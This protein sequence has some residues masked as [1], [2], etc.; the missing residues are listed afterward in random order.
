MK[1]D[2]NEKIS[3][4]EIWK[5]MY[6]VMLLTLAQKA[7]S[8]FEGIL[9][10]INNSRELTVTSVCGPYISIIT[11]V[12][13]GLGIAVQV[14]TARINGKQDWK[15]AGRAILG[16]I[17][18]MVLAC[19]I[20]ISC[21]SAIL[22]YP[23]FEAAPELRQ[24]GYLYM[25]PYLLG[26]P[27]ILLYHIII[28]EL[29]GF[30][31]TRTGMW[32]TFLSVPIQLGLCWLFYNYIGFT[33]MGYSMLISRISG[34]IY[35]LRKSNN[36][37]R[38]LWKEEKTQLP[39]GFFTEFISLALPI[40]LSK[41]ISPSANAVMNSLLLTMGT[42]IVAVSGLGNRLSVFFYL[43]ATAVGVAAV[44]LVPGIQNKTE[45]NNICRRLC[46]WSV[47]PTFVLVLAAYIFRVPI[48]NLLSADMAV[49]SVG[50]EYWKICLVAYPLISIEMTMTSLLQA[51]GYGMPTLVITTVRIWGVQLPLT[52]LAKHLGFHA[53]GAWLAYLLS[54][55]VSVIISVIWGY[56]KIKRKKSGE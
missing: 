12:S 22:L 24:T 54:N 46:F 56:S 6:P 45:L 28:A 5:L 35:G 29:R 15:D 43:P 50:Y 18:W 9:V 21:V 25:I 10:S 55:V 17:F 52:Y 27:V 47:G 37:R 34:C 20:L 19:S 53:A 33:A 3:N 36:C 44:T 2:Y 26:S 40:S 4:R 41:M 11:T 13:Y 32:M 39:E 38:N 14:M 8:V 23:A 16:K 48:W 42:E 51:M 7:G 31:D 30:G 49:R 1:P